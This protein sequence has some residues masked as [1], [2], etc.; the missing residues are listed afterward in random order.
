MCVLALGTVPG[1]GPSFCR[2]SE[3]VNARYAA[4]N[5]GTNN[6]QSKKTCMDDPRRSRFEIALKKQDLSKRYLTDDEAHARR[7]ETKS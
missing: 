6:G 5:E 3:V 4:H 2:L 7:C 1:A